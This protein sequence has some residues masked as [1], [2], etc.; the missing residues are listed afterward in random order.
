MS[1]TV[2][3]ACGL[4]KAFGR[5]EGLVRAVSRSFFRTER[6]SCS[7]AQLFRMGQREIALW[8]RRLAG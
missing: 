3:Q 2:L 8:G 4:S 1:E 6:G 7:R 5:G